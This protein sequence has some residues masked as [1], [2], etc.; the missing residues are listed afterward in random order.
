MRLEV[1]PQH[2]RRYRR[3]LGYL[4]LRRRSL[5]GLVGSFLGWLLKGIV[6]WLG[7]LCLED[8]IR[9]GRTCHFALR[10]PGRPGTASVCPGQR[11]PGGTLL[12]REQFAQLAVRL[13]PNHVHLFGV[14]AFETF[15]PVLENLANSASLLGAED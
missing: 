4:R 14:R 15:I 6:R 5:G 7:R 13:V 3:L 2:P 1:E 8:V 12:L 9:V 10:R 11:R